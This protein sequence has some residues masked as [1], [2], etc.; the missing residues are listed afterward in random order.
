MPTLSQELKQESNLGIQGIEERTP[1]EVLNHI[2]NRLS[3][4]FE[5]GREIEISSNPPS[6]ERV[7]YTVRVKDGV[8][9]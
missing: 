8:G 9:K 7:C 4:G 5:K 6:A 3:I 2:E 1:T